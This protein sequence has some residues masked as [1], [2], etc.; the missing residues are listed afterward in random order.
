MSW[1]RTFLIAI[2]IGLSSHAVADTYLLMAEEDG[3]YWCARWNKEIADIYPKTVEGQA[4]PLRRYDLNRDQ[5]GVQL[6]SKVVFTPTFV[7]VKDGAEI[8][9]I[10]GYPG[11]DFFW[12]LLAEMLDKAKIS[13]KMAR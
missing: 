2:I 3:C 12:P 8:D 11:E 9:R 5:P 10:E 1:I 7:L 13:L 6:S 4:A